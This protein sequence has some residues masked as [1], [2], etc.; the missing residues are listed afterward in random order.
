MKRRAITLLLSTALLSNMSACTI[1][2]NYTDGDSVSEK[3]HTSEI[4]KEIIAEVQTEVSKTEEGEFSSHRF[5]Q[6]NII[7]PSV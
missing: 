4:Q 2:P 5:F 1:V 6:Q 3:T 7:E